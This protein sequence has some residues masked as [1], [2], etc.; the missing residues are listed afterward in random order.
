MKIVALRILADTLRSYRDGVPRLL[1][2]LDEISAKGSF[3]FGM[4]SERSGSAMSK[5]FGAEKEIVP[6]APGILKDAFKRGHDCGVCGMN[7][8]EWRARL[9]KLPDT[10]VLANIKNA[11]SNFRKR[12]GS[13]PNGFA[14]PGFRVNYISLRT[15]DDAGFKY[16]SDTFGFCPFIPKMS[17]K[18]FAIPQIPS[19]LP[20]LEDL[21]RRLQPQEAMNL[22]SNMDDG[23]NVLPVDAELAASQDAL[24][25]IRAFMERAAG[26]GVKFLDMLTVAKNIDI[27]A[28][29]ICEI[30][31]RGSLG[32]QAKEPK[33]NNNVS[34]H[35]SPREEP[36]HWIPI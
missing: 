19:T 15:L 11:H 18:I 14:S 24:G 6:S 13:P 10:S 8:R 3:F 9:D 34:S 22:L 4:G 25:F 30:N 2:A 28:L 5:L 1:D 27:K 21:L 23:L 36:P 35:E 17:K 20:T 29:P 31:Y 32:V 7:P 33:P 16:C 12:V 26:D